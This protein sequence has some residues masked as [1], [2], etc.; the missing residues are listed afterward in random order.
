MPA[1]SS[2]S[3]ALLLPVL[4]CFAL[5]HHNHMSLII[6]YL[7]GNIIGDK[8][9]FAYH[10]LFEFQGLGDFTLDEAD[11][12]A[13]GLQLARVVHRVLAGERPDM[14]SSCRPGA[15]RRVVDGVFWSHCV[16]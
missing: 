16:S 11:Y 3:S 9:V 1:V 5:T 2:L 6:G 8:S 10:W 15:T 13:D 4:A 14:Y 12:F 7:K